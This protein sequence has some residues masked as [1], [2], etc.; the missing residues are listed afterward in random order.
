MPKK[1]EGVGYVV[2]NTCEYTGRGDYGLRHLSDLYGN[3]LGMVMPT[4]FEHRV[5]C[6]Y[7]V[8]ACYRG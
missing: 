5:D 8:G 6:P 2:N 3:E 7:L 1:G 4:R